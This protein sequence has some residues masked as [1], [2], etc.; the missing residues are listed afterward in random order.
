MILQLLQRFLPISGKV[1]ISVQAKT[2][3]AVS[4]GYFDVTNPKI[5]NVF[6]LSGTFGDEITITG[7]NLL[8]LTGVPTV[9]FGG[10]RSCC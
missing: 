4:T 7:E 10:N 3:T 5:S 1:K 6:P 9:T 2:Q 8:S